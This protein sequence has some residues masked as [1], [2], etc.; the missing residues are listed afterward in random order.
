VIETAEFAGL[1]LGKI[2]DALDSKIII[3]KKR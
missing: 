2:G 3:A 1:P